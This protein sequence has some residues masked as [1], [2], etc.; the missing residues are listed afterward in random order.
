MKKI[1]FN[2]TYG[3]TKAVREGM[4]TLTRRFIPEKLGEIHYRST[5]A[6]GYFFSDA[7]DHEIVPAF[8]V[9]EIVAIAQPYQDILPELNDRQREYV[10]DFY[11]GTPGWA[12]KM[13]VRADLMSHHIQITDIR[14]E[15]IQDISWEDCLKEGV[16]P[17]FSGYYVP[18]LKCKDWTKESHVDA[19]DGQ[20]WKLFSTPIEAFK[21]LITKLD[22]K[23]WDKNLQVFVY[24]FKII[25]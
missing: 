4:K 7:D 15:R 14:L 22:K 20:T 24:E 19:E 6:G 23:A 16:L 25:D 3:L 5:V 13:Y 18:G 12:N 21:T 2:D 10:I 9:G 8:S 1:M 11:S 17:S